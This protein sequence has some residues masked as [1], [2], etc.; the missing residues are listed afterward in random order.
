M[1]AYVLSLPSVEQLEKDHQYEFS[2]LLS[3]IKKNIKS[4]SMEAHIKNNLIP[5]AYFILGG[6]RKGLS[7]EICSGLVEPGDLRE[8]RG[9]ASF[10]G[11]P[12][13]YTELDIPH[14]NIFPA[15]VCKVEGG[16]MPWTDACSFSTSSLTEIQ[17][18]I[19]KKIQSAP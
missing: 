11:I 3:S 8:R 2:V 7:N 18:Y 13:G 17:G 5:L 6:E 4:K 9:I 19:K 14:T 16:D 1:D 15:D 10:S 12:L